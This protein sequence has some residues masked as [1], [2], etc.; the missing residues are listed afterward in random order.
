MPNWCTNLL[1]I[2]NSEEFEKTMNTPDMN[3]EIAK[4]SFHQTV[5]FPENG[6]RGMLSLQDKEECAKKGI[7][8]WYDW[9]SKEW[10]TKWDACDVIVDRNPKLEIRFET[11]WSPPI[12]WL[13]AVSLKFP[14][15]KFTLKCCE[16]GMGYYGTITA[17]NGEVQDKTKSGSYSNLS[18]FANRWGIGVGG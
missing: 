17:Q 16:C 8:N 7:P 3:G 13:K 2:S 14:K 15:S 5:P 18:K 1:M 10:G 12:A 6:F 4:F 9:C 11:A